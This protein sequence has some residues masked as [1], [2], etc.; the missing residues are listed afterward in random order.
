MKVVTDTADD[1]RA[2][3]GPPGPGLLVAAHRAADLRAGSMTMVVQPA[4]DLHPIIGGAV[5]DAQCHQ[6]MEQARVRRA[7]DPSQASAPRALI[8][9]VFRRT[10]WRRKMGRFEL[11]TVRAMYAMIDDRLGQG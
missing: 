1:D 3:H 2:D 10:S 9:Q 5:R 11:D 4:A 7:V 8:K 6:E